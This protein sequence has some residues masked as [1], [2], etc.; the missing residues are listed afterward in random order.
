MGRSGGTGVS[1]DKSKDLDKIPPKNFVPFTEDE[2]WAKTRQEM[3]ETLNERQQR[4]CE[5]YVKSFNAEL[6][7]IKS[8]YAKSTAHLV[9][10]RMRKREDVRSYLAWLKLRAT[11][12]LD[13]SP[14]DILEQYAKIGFADIT[15]YVSL[16]NG[17]L[18][19]ADS[20]Q[21][22]GQVVKS[23]KTGPQGTTIELYDKLSALR[24]LEQFFSEMP[25]SWQ[26][27]L[28]ERRLELA[29]EK[30]A[31]EREAL[32]NATDHT[33]LTVLGRQAYQCG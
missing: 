11:E 6:A 8:G 3:T 1:R 9:G 13:I 15:D 25:K 21:I 33:Y 23:Y 16:K 5:I 32:G 18:T 30:L 27:R 19:L 2:L 24:H 26:Q 29:E 10:K 31:L 4:W 17:R 20:D 22:D 12:T 7:A 14:M 28:E